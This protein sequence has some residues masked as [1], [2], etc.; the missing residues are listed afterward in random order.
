MK[1]EL[2]ALLMDWK[3]E[4]KEKEK[5]QE[6][7][8][9]FGLNNSV[10]G[11]VTNEIGKIGRGPALQGKSRF[12]FFCLDTLGGLRYLS[13]LTRD[14]TRTTTVKASSPN[15]WTVRE[16]PQDSILIR[17]SLKCLFGLRSGKV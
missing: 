10:N 17:L 12:L 13:S 11:A 7:H 8:Y 3:G 14:R 1:T 2:K 6:G 4:T 15:S 9:I 16:V 5:N